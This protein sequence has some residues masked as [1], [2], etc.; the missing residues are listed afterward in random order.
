MFRKGVNSKMTIFNFKSGSNPYIAKTEKEKERILKKYKNYEI[1]KT[2]GLF[3]YIYTI[4]DT[5]K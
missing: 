2:K 5:K 3:A 1:S 4:D